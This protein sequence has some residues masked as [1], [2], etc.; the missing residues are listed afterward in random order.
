MLVKSF[1]PAF[2]RLK[3]YTTSSNID[4]SNRYAGGGASRRRRHSHTSVI[5]HRQRRTLGESN[6]AG[7]DLFFLF[8]ASGSIKREDFEASIQFAMRL[9]REVST[10]QLNADDAKS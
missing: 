6:V 3:Y 1:R 9:V 10:N 8:D 7:L 2:D 4:Q 5:H